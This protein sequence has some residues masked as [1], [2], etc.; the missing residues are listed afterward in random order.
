VGDDLVFRGKFVV[1]A[2]HSGGGEG[3]VT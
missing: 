1:F 2:V 3:G